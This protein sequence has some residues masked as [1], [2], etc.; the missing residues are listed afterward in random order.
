[1]AVKLERKP[2]EQKTKPEFMVVIWGCVEWSKKCSPMYSSQ[3]KSEGGGRGG[4]WKGFFLSF[5]QLFLGYFDFQ[6]F[7]RVVSTFCYEANISLLIFLT[8]V[9]KR[10]NMLLKFK[11][12]I[13]GCDWAKPLGEAAPA[14]NI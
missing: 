7:K 4:R 9:N 8:A 11:H 1:M 10:G 2:I 12:E 3:P 6:L 14:I 5:H 13:S